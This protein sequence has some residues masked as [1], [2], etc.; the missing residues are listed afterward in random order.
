MVIG[1]SLLTGCRALGTKPS[2][3]T[4]YTVVSGTVVNGDWVD[5][6]A[7]AGNDGEALS[8]YPDQ[9]EQEPVARELV[10]QVRAAIADFRHGSVRRN[11]T[12]RGDHLRLTFPRGRTRRSFRTNCLHGL[13][14]LKPM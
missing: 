7:H 6:P 10:E 12:A 1:V 8:G 14:Y 13:R 5:Y 4:F 3:T 2:P 9:G 11:I